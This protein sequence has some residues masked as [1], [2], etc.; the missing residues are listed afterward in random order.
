[1]SFIR[2]HVWRHGN[3]RCLSLSHE[4]RWLVIP[5]RGHSGLIYLPGLYQTMISIF[6][7]VWNIVDKKINKYLKKKT[8]TR[9]K[10]ANNK[11]FEKSFFPGYRKVDFTIQLTGV[12]FRVIDLGINRFHAQH[13][14][15]ILYKVKV[16]NGQTNRQTDLLGLTL[17]LLYINHVAYNSTPKPKIPYRSCKFDGMGSTPHLV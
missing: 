7:Y 3:D 13:N 4:G 1:M 11:L 5:I 2:P 15:S 16:D 17:C 6:A 9:N 12:G 10:S 14:G 8:E